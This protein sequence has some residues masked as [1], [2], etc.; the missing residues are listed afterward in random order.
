MQRTQTITI[1]ESAA[2]LPTMIVGAHRAADGTL[3]SYEYS[4]NLD[5][6]RFAAHERHVEHS[7]S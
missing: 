3:R 1:V 6:G 5:P 7:R 4:P 2:V